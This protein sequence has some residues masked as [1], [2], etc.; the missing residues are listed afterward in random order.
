MDLSFSDDDP[1]QMVIYGRSGTGKTTLWSTFPAPILALVCSGGL[2]P[3]ELRSVDTAENRKRIKTFNIKSA[4]QVQE[5]ADA[6]KEDCRY[7]TVV[8]DHVTSFADLILKDILGLDEIPVSKTFG[9][10][11]QQDYGQM[12]NQGKQIIRSLLSVPA[13]IVVVA[14]ERKD[15]ADA[16]SDSI[17]QP[18]I[19]AELTPK[20]AAWL[21]ASFDYVCQTFIRPKTEKMKTVLG[22]GPKAKV[23][24]KERVVPDKYEYCLR[25]GESD[26]FASKF[27]MPLGI[28]KPTQ[29]VDPTYDKVM[30]FIR[31][32]RNAE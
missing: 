13:N 23:V 3:G 10:A 32:E 31:G 28:P 12:T 25:T 29:I 8:L 6:L 18:F 5:F 7:K 30:K 1:I 24:Y 4:E 17:I 26:T 11:H 14:Q 20:F 27:R 2:N 19:G 16:Q 9:L 22:K 15:N 21:H